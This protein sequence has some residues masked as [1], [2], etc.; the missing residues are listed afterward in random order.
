LPEAVSP[1]AGSGTPAAEVEIDV[2]LVRALIAAQHPDLASLV[3]TPFA[4]GWD[5]AMFRV[6]EA[7]V[8][9]LPRR[10]AAAGL[11]ET[12]QRW[13]PGLAAGLPV[14]VPAATRTGEPGLGYPWRWS[15]LPWIEGAAADLSPP[16]ASE[17]E[18][19]TGFLLALHRPAPAEAPHNPHR[20]VP[21]ADRA[22]VLEQ[23]M[24]RLEAAGDT[25]HPAVRAALSDAI[26]APPAPAKTWIHGDLHA[27]NVLTDHG[28][29]SGVIDWGDMAA[30]DPATDL[31]TAWALFADAAARH[32]VLGAYGADETLRRRARGWAVFFGVMLLEAGRVNDA[33]LAEAGAATLAR[34]AQDA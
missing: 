25:V 4:A 18:T 2:A 26:A 22:E 32:A 28:V 16:A 27:R 17:A 1:P 3:V 24:A 19:L 21:L 7:L 34:V 29:I 15:L 11:I 33:R 5:N 23:R 30:G 20:S 10:A 12:E 9:R 13:L 8:A 14:P 6:G 31:A